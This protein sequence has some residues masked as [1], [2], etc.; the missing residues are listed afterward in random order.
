VSLRALRAAAA[1]VIAA[2]ALVSPT[3]PA[4]ADAVRDNQWHLRILDV[5]EAHKVSQGENVTVA[6][7]DSG[8]EPHPDLRDNLLKGTDVVPG[9]TSDG[10]DDADGHGT[11]MAGLIAAHG[12]GGDDGALGIAPKAKILPIR[13]STSAQNADSVNLASGI[14]YAIQQGADVISVSLAGS[15]R[16]ELS[17][18]VEAALAA[19][20]VIVAGVGNRPSQIVVSFPAFLDGVL[21][22]GAS[23]KK[24]NHA[25][26]SVTGDKVQLVAP[27]V[28]IHSTNRGGGYVRSNGTSNSTAI[29]AGAAA[30]VR[31]KYPD[32]SAQEVVHRLTATATDKG[33]PGRDPEYGYGVLN[34]VAA[35]TANVPLLQPSGATSPD[36]T[37]GP[38]PSATALPSP[39]TDRTGVFA[40]LGVSLLLLIAAAIGAAVVLAARRRKT[41]PQSGV[42]GQP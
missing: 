11:A 35:L 9:G 4:H 7:I 40:L 17:R 14:D 25:A 36:G 29:V 21:A 31:S 34:L 13:N 30:L 37:A 2:A 41:T 20:I 8:V 10:R 27:G 28:D 6:V 22:V 18:A 39:G 16:P 3:T 5:A 24:G 26:I 1:V 38:G 23:D 42:A 15:P 33:A 32:L 19:D 12:K